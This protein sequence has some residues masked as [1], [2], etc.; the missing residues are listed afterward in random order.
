MLE[1]NVISSLFVHYISYMVTFTLFIC[2]IQIQ[3]A[4]ICTVYILLDA[5]SCGLKRE[6]KTF[7]SL[8]EFM[9]FDNIW[10]KNLNLAF[11]PIWQP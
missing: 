1:C 11:Q 3:N 10:V 2:L 7:F 8:I 6:A 4:E 5:P 9:P